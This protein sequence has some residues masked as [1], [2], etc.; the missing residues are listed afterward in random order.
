MRVCGARAGEAGA[1]GAARGSGVQWAGSGPTG[2]LE[3][4]PWGT[5]SCS[6]GA[7]LRRC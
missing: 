1:G 5:G 3:P 7:L 4:R 2:P 6:A